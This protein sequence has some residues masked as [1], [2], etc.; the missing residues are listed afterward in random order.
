[1]TMEVIKTS[2]VRGSETGWAKA[3]RL[4]GKGIRT[5]V[6]ATVEGDAGRPRRGDDWN[7]VRGED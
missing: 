4:R 5:W 6:R 2:G 3:R 7:V 1:M